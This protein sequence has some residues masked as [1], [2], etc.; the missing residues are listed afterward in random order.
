ML[1]QGGQE[2]L[3]TRPLEEVL[4]DTSLLSGGMDLV[5]EGETIGR[6]TIL[7]SRDGIRQSAWA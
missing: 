4:A 2:A 5:H 7:L 6:F 3:L 1:A